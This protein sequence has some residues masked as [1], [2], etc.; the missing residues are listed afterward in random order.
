MNPND[1]D[2]SF[3]NRSYEPPSVRRLPNSLGFDL[4]N[5]DIVGEARAPAETN[6]V[7]G[8]GVLERSLV[9][10]WVTSPERIEGV[11][12]DSYAGT[13]THFAVGAMWFDENAPVFL[14][15]GGHHLASGF[16]VTEHALGPAIRLEQGATLMLYGDMDLY[17]GSQIPH[18]RAKAV[19]SIHAQA[20][21]VVQ[22]WRE[23]MGA[24]AFGEAVDALAKALEGKPDAGK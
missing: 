14:F 8:P 3:A 24:A 12:R 4:L 19:E 22:A 20:L 10:P 21:A 13:T 5:D 6:Y 18:I 15:R 16:E 17:L 2:P 9:K 23:D 1:P 11:M 7:F